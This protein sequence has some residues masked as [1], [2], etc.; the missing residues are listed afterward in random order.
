MSTSNLL[1]P[2]VN[3]ETVFQELLDIA[4]KF[5]PDT[6]F[7]PCRNNPTTGQKPPCKEAL[8]W[9]SGKYTVDT[10]VNFPQMTCLGL[11]LKEQYIALDCDGVT[12][13][14]KYDELATLYGAT[15][16]LKLSSDPNTRQG[17]I[18]RRKTDL[19]L[20]KELKPQTHQTLVDFENDR[21]EQFEIRTGKQYQI[22]AG[23]HPKKGIYLHNNADIADL[24]E[25][26]YD[27]IFNVCDEFIADSTD[28][29]QLWGILERLRV[30][31]DFFG[32]D[33]DTWL[34]I[35]MIIHHAI[36][37][38][39]KGLE[40]F[41][42]W[43]KKF[44]G[45]QSTDDEEYTKKWKSFDKDT[46]NALTV[47]S[48][49][50]WLMERQGTPETVK[51][52]PKVETLVKELDKIV[53][54][55]TIGMLHKE[56]DFYKVQGLSSAVIDVFAETIVKKV[57]KYPNRI[58]IDY[59]RNYLSEDSEKNQDL[60]QIINDLIEAEK[61]QLDVSWVLAGTKVGKA[62]TDHAINSAAPSEYFLMSFLS[63]YSAALPKKYSFNF[64][65]NAYVIPAIFVLLMGGAT[66]GKS[67]FTNPFVIPLEKLAVEKNNLFID[68][69]RQYKDKIEDWKQT[70]KTPGGKKELEEY[71]LQEAN[72]TYNDEN[73]KLSQMRDFLIP[74]PVEQNPGI[75][76]D[77]S[78]EEMKRLSGRHQK[79][80]IGIAPR[81]IKDLL[82][83]ISQISKTNQS[84]LSKLI[85][86]WDGAS[87]LRHRVGG[88][89]EKASM[90]QV[91]LLSTTQTDIFY[92][93]FDTKED[94]TGAMSRFLIIPITEDITIPSKLP[95]ESK[96][97]ILSNEFMDLFKR[98]ENSLKFAFEDTMIVKNSQEVL[99]LW[100]AWRKKQD[101]NAKQVEGTNK[102]FYKWLRRNPEYTA[103]IALIIHSLRCIEEVENDFTTMST[104]SMLRAI[105]ISHWLTQKAQIV[106]NQSLNPKASS[107]NPEENKM[108]RDF[109]KYCGGQPRTTGFFG[110]GHSFVR[111]LDVLDVYGKKGQKYLNK[112]QIT[113]LFKDAEKGG[114][115]TCK[116]D[117][118]GIVT[119]TPN[120]TV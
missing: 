107:T 116:T 8:D 20:G 93:Y 35:G 41:R 114:L 89:R 40:L 111:R 105:S 120:Q 47:G 22:I 83:T 88:E 94:E 24:P 68:A 63:M 3:K 77:S 46:N 65:D 31:D 29:T 76:T 69:E 61:C 56:A 2:S 87:T 12:A 49:Y 17:I 18:Y 62:L 21:K 73:L 30:C 60:N 108:F 19:Q 4:A 119:F 14:K 1:T 71:Y 43:S 84:S 67:I 58:L 70:S 115:G 38:S 91:S 36:E 74:E 59:V 15:D 79:K 110:S 95:T 78:F 32:T 98:T 51:N 54:E 103:R 48:L 113:K 50:Y 106:F 28:Q 96:P 97:N 7:V 81:E 25:P 11:L 34:R 101:A 23:L 53:H 16:T 66:S 100:D 118:K 45:Y 13:I 75:I 104:E 39:D 86:V 10:L 55:G 117:G 72:K 5:P 80:A 52:N 82:D 37:D 109:L 85:A 90:F 92:K 6:S 112:P 44:P 102:G 26:W 99:N 42:I 33:Y 27:Y 57:T 9:Q 64:N